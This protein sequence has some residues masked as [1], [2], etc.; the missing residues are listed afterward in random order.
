MIMDTIVN[1]AQISVGVMQFSIAAALVGAAAF[2]AWAAKH[3]EQS[4]V[5]EIKVY[6]GG[7][8]RR[9]QS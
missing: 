1:V 2:S 4:N 8:N 7:C 9:T 5:E 6:R 3:Q